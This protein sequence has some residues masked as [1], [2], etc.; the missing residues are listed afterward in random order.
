MNWPWIFGYKPQRNYQ[1]S[2]FGA[3]DR[4][5]S[6]NGGSICGVMALVP[7]A[8]IRSKAAHFSNH[9]SS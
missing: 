8:F 2:I 5:L 1:G 9:P 3:I 6:S 4:Y 7:R